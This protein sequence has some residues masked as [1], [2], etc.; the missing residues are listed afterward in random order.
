MPAGVLLHVPVPQWTLAMW[1]LRKSELHWPK[2]SKTHPTVH[3]LQIYSWMYALA[4]WQKLSWIRSHEWICSTAKA[5]LYSLLKWHC[6]PRPS[7]IFDF[8]LNLSDLLRKAR[9][10]TNMPFCSCFLFT[11][12]VWKRVPDISELCSANKTWVV[13]QV[14]WSSCNIFSTQDHAAAAI[15]KA[16]IPG[17]FSMF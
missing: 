5:L 4:A 6:F 7:D 3:F 14:Q 9:T 1:L 17:K 2:F 11:S 10:Y 13:F 12:C 16:G 8:H 15:A